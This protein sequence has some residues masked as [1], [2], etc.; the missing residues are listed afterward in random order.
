MPTSLPQ[1]VFD[2]SIVTAVPTHFETEHPSDTAQYDAIKSIQKKNVAAFKRARG[3]PD[4]LYPLASALGAH[5]ADAVKRIQDAG[6]IVFHAAGDT[7]A[8]N[9]RLYKNELQVADMLAADYHTSDP[10]SV[11]P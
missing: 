9:A 11:A 7:G 3:K 2:E 10:A 4:A 6:Q 5:G 8:S 1:P